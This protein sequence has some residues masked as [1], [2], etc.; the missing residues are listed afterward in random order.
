MF[1][2][3]FGHG[4]KL[5][6]CWSLRSAERRWHENFAVEARNFLTKIA[7]EIYWTFLA[8][9]SAVP[10]RGRSKCSRTQKQANELKRAQMQV[11]KRASKG[12]KERKRA[13]LRK[14]CKAPDLKQPGLGIPNCFVGPKIS[15]PPNFPQDFHVKNQENL[16][17]S[18]CKGAGGRKCLFVSCFVWARSGVI[19]STIYLGGC[20]STV[21]L[22]S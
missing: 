7:P 15:S 18:F 6:K 11:C 22:L 3:G 19:L 1:E 2:Y 4:S 17:T 21:P 14:N 16:P 13:L 9:V 20:P 10:E 5:W 12:A 8:F